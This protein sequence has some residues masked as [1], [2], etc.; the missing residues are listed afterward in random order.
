MYT[1]VLHCCTVCLSHFKSAWYCNEYIM[2]DILYTTVCTLCTHTHIAE[3]CNEYMQCSMCRGV[4]TLQDM[5]CI[6]LQSRICNAWYCKAQSALNKVLLLLLVSLCV[7]IWYR[8]GHHINAGHNLLSWVCQ[9]AFASEGNFPAEQIVHISWGLNCIK[10]TKAPK[11]E[12]WPDP[13][14]F[15][16]P[17]PKLRDIEPNKKKWTKRASKKISN[18][19]Q[20]CHTGARKR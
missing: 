17:T 1:S 6:I 12:Y 11:I 18:I 15:V 19:G 14:A 16:H 5:Q 4:C 9:I 3:Y 20:C 8:G 2:Q 7:S 13:P 10:T